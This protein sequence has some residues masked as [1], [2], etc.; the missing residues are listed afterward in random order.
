MAR[1]LWLLMALALGAKAHPH[2]RIADQVALVRF[3]IFLSYLATNMFI[4]AGVVRHWND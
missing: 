1:R 3:A 2:D 4:I